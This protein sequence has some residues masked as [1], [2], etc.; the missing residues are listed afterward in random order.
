MLFDVQR[1]TKPAISEAYHYLLHYYSLGKS[2]RTGQ[3]QKR[4]ITVAAYILIAISKVLFLEGKLALVS[5][6]TQF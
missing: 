2:C 4:L 6:S 3:K 5:I 1:S